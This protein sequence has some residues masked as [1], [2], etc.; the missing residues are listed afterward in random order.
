MTQ[1]PNRSSPL[2][3]LRKPPG[4]P[5]WVLARELMVPR[6]I[7]R[8][9]ST[10]FFLIFLFLFFSQNATN[11]CLCQ[12]ANTSQVQLQSLPNPIASQSPT[13]LS[14]S[15]DPN[16]LVLRA[17]Q[18]A[19][20]GPSVH[21]IVKQ[22]S[23]LGEF[24]LV[25]EGEYWAAGQGTG[26]MKMTMQLMA[27]ELQTNMIQV[28]DGRLVWTSTSDDEPPRRVFLD[29]VRRELGSMAR[30][31]SGHPQA[32]L[33][34]AIGGHAEMLRCLYYRYRWFKVWAGKDEKGTN[35]WQLVGTLRTEA[36]SIASYTI[37]DSYYIQQSPPPELP[38]DVRLTLDRD[39]KLPLFPY[40]V[41][42]FRREPSLDGIP[43]KLVL[44]SSVTHTEIETPITITK[45]L[46]QYQ[47]RE[48]ADR[49][50]NETS[51]YLPLYP[52]ADAGTSQRR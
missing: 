33:Y 15:L 52:I 10:G 16:Q 8:G 45:E 35:V 3:R 12:D 11:I 39:D 19:V 34:L 48:D 20:W 1:K 28:S 29:E 17:V 26:Q 9:T 41:E 36:P 6:G 46:F 21:S 13:S 2:G 27:G 51:E 7:H 37:V 23:E 38:T 14:N 30:N 43:G 40:K 44:L 25:G 18:Q 42:Y 49:I 24:Q 47:V 32:A 4:L 31:P 5:D 50:E 22:R